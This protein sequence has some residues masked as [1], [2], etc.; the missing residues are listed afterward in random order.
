MHLITRGFGKTSVI[1]GGTYFLQHIHSSLGEG[2]IIKSNNLS[3]TQTANV[4]GNGYINTYNKNIIN[5]SFD[6]LTRGGE[7]WVNGNKS[8]EK[9]FND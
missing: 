9:W 5:T 2:F 7:L 3:F 8:D 1:N 6:K 4:L